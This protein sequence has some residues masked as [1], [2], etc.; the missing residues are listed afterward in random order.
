MFRPLPLFIGLRYTRGKRRNHFISFISW[1]SMVGIA[2]GVATL[3]T[4]LSVMNGFDTV[5]KDR[6]LGMAPQIRISTFNGVL[7]HWE[8]LAQRIAH[9]PGVIGVAP[10]VTGQSM[11]VNLGTTTAAM[12][13]GIDPKLEAQVSGIGQM[14]SKGSLSAL[15]PG[16]FGIVVGNSLADN[17]GLTL[18][19]KVTVVTPEA[20]LTAAGVIPRFKRFTV[21]GIFSA[22]SGFGFDDHLGY[23]NLEDA[24][25]LYDIPDI[26]GLR[27]KIT[28]LYAAPRM[29]QA[30]AKQF[31]GRYLVSN[32]TE[33]FGAF[34]SAIALEKNMIF[35]ILLLIVAVA[36]F[37]L[38][39][40]LVM[41]VTDKQAD[42]AIL[43]TFG[44]SPR[45]IL[46]IFIVQGAVI[47]LAGT[48]LGL[49]GGVLLASHATGIANTLQSIFGVQL[50]SSNLYYV[51]YLP[52][53][54]EL[55]DV[56]EICSIA[57]G[58]SLLATLYPA[59]RASRVQPAEA[60]RYE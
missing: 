12:V 34:F 9:F 46:Q 2:L 49:I 8:A 17:L 7:P 39:S 27:L 32:W 20:T 24:K 35:I 4:V 3:I 58:L 55:S 43:R 38:V 37:N 40:T 45:T 23:I 29:T 11:M 48:I 31:S 22:G 53:K 10:Y 60:L 18:G 5:I 13:T 25:K 26:T 21:V 16:S 57:F 15:K 36:A 59:W 47:G 33:D 41:V 52:S 54:L 28:D 6:V 44:A 50:L 1:M 42:I 14:I 30:L 56:V 51:D 19:D